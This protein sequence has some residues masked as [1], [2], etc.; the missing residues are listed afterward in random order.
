MSISNFLYYLNK[1][2][3]NVEEKKDAGH[4][5]EKQGVMPRRETNA[6]HFN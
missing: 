2:E 6:G 4:I 5:V 1:A 3:E